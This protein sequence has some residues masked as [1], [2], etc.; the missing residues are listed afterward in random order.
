MTSRNQSLAL[1]ENRLSLGRETLKARIPVLGDS[2]KNHERQYLPIHWCL[3]ALALLLLIPAFVYSH[4]APSVDWANLLGQYWI[5]LGVRAVFCAVILYVVQWPKQ[6]LLPVWNRYRKEPLRFVGA[7]IF[8]AFMFRIFGPALGWVVLIDGLALAEILD[9]TDGSLDRISNL[10]RPLAWPAIYLFVGLVA[11]FT[12]NDLIACLRNLGSYDWFYLKIDSWLAP[13]LSV[14]ALSKAALTSAPTWTLKAIEFVYYGMFGQIGSALILVSLMY[15]RREGLRYVGTILTAYFVALA[16][17]Y[18][19]PSM[20]PFYSCQDHF[21]HF[22]KGL[23]TYGIQQT[24]ILKMKL[25]GASRYRPFNRVETDYFIAFPCMHIAQP[26]IVLWFLRKQRRIR[27][28]LIAHDVLLVPAI[29][30]LEWHYY[31]DLLGGV[32]VAIVAI[33]LN[34]LQFRKIVN[35]TQSITT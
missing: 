22:P 31:S 3:V 24:A 12:Y 18:L 34:D 35:E 25:L 9:R 27:M 6:T 8:A 21:A 7:S 28:L 14:S 20:G 13:S 30:L 17:F 11:M 33:V 10:L 4:L 1:N 19:W 2:G 5:G 16:V 23:S 29:L 26:L 15:G 32:L